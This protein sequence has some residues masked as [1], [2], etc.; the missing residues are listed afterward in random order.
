MPGQPVFA[1]SIFAGFLLGLEIML[2]SLGA[3]ESRPVPTPATRQEVWRAVVAELRQRGLAEA[4]L[5][6]VEEMDLANVPAALTGRSLRVASACWDEGP[7]RTQFRLEC[8]KEGQCLPFLVYVR[9]FV[10]DYAPDFVRDSADADAGGRARSCRIAAGPR[11]VLASRTATEAVPKPTVRPGDRATAV[12]VSSHMRMTA[13]V[14]CLERGHEGEVIRVRASDGHVFRARVS[15][16]AFVE[17]LL[18]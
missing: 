3:E 17:A 2:G 1:Q 6:R 9:D 4:Q 14:T 15:G 16:P 18:Q 5:P 8:G 13:S 12:F 10:P 11:P 7:R